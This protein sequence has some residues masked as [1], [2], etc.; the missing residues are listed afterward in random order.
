[1]SVQTRSRSDKNAAVLGSREPR[2]VLAFL[3]GLHRHTAPLPAAN[4]EMRACKRQRYVL[5]PQGFGCKRQRPAYMLKVFNKPQA[6]FLPT[7]LYSSASMR[8]VYNAATPVLQTAAISPYSH[9]FPKEPIK[10]RQCLARYF[11]SLALLRFFLSESAAPWE[12]MA[13]RA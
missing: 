3:N 13:V 2:Q 8:R 10:K 12:L 5:C 7:F 1:M 9:L 4:R 6:V 11:T